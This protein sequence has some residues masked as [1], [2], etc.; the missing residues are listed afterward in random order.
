MI[1]SYLLSCVSSARDDGHA[2]DFED[3]NYVSLFDLIILHTANSH[4]MLAV[5]VDDVVNVLGTSCAR[6]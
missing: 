2:A 4:F 3:C 5:V 6:C 1:L